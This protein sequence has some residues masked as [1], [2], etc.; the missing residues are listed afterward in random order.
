MC[1]IAGVFGSAD[2][3]TVAAMLDKLYHRG[4][5]DGHQVSG[6]NY[7]FGARRLSIVGIAD[8]RQPL[9]NEDGN[10]WAAQNGELYNYPEQKKWLLERSHKL[11]TSCDT[12]II[13]HLYEEYG[14]AFPEHLDGMFA[15]A[16]WDKREQIGILA[17]DRMGKKPLYYLEVDGKVYF[18]SEI[19]S[20]LVVP[21]F[22][23]RINHQALNYY[24]ALKHVPCPLT[25]FEGLKMLPPGCRLIFKPGQAVTIEKYWDLNWSTSPEYERMSEDELVDL[26]LD[27]LRQGVKRRLMSDVPVGFFLS[28]GIDSSLSS[29]LATE[30]S[31]TKIKTFTLTYGDS[32]TTSGKE[33]DRYWARWT[34]DKYQTEHYEETVEFKDFPENLRKVI[35]CFDE[36]FAGTIS[37]FF[38]AG[39]IAKHVKVAISGDGADELFGSYLSHR[40]A[41]PL[42]NYPRFQDSGDTSLLAPFQNQR[43]YLQSLYEQEDYNWRAKLLVYS[44]EEKER[45]VSS[46]GKARDGNAR[47]LLQRDFSTL[48]ATQPLNRILEAEFHTIFADQ[49]LA[50]VDRLSMAHSLEIRSAFLD[51]RVVEFAARLPDNLKIR[52]GETKYL[53]KKAASRYFPE[54]MVF[55]RKEGFIMPITDWLL[56]DLETYVRD[57]LSPGQ[58]SRHGLFNNDFVQDLLEKI[59]KDKDKSDYRQVNK[60][61]SLVVFQEWFNLYMN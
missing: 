59:Y 53:L 5:D 12:E 15:I 25:I 28:G 2:S 37:T 61:Y 44:E 14:S 6:Q 55:R 38:L 35:G 32:S 56:G 4:P 11:N 30:M 48:T 42:A 43:D 57:T 22:A 13:Q 39:L 45:L 40:L 8:G 60:L 10:I 16:V 46:A 47:H 58:L 17:R 20:L 50:F 51:T 33:Q 34:K 24:L 26:L 9:C 18:A 41:I 7:A 21:G 29:V 54:E 1:G 31:S 3:G 23:R 36:P 27:K 49:V 52:N 19:K